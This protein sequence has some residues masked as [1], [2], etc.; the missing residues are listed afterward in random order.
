[1]VRTEGEVV[2]WRG[3]L[4]MEGRE[5]GGEGGAGGEV[6][7]GAKE[8]GEVIARERKRCNAGIKV[9]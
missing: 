6:R 7:G 5:G 4:S 3:A 9:K 8:T 1:M 2:M